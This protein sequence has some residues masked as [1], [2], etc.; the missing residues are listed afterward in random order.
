[1]PKLHKLVPNYVQVKYTGKE[2]SWEKFDET[3][4]QADVLVSFNWYNY[5][6]DYKTVQTL[7]ANYLE[8][9][10]RMDEHKLWAK[11][12]AYGVKNGIGWYARMICMGYPATEA[13]VERVDNAIAFALTNIPAKMPRSS[14]VTTEENAK[15]KAG[16][17]E[18]MRERAD[19]LGGELEYMFDLFMDEGAKSKHKHSPINAL[20][21][22]N[23]L[24]Q[25][26]S[27]L[28]E[29]WEQVRDEFAQAYSGVIK[30]LNESYSDY[31]KIQLRNIVKFTDLVIA[32][33]NSYVTFKKTQRATPKRKV[34]TP[35]QQVQKL[36]HAKECKELNL[37]SVKPEKILGAKEMF[38]YSPKKRKLTYYV[39]DESAGNALMVKNN[40]IVGFDSD[41]TVMKTIRTPKTQIK[42]L[43]KASRPLTRK[44]FKGIRTVEA[45]VS[46]RFADD[47]VILKVF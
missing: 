1:M 9:N 4:R 41:L 11:V 18:L 30:D 27:S 45:K 42:E 10:E 31:T 22:A 24:P 47:L 2:P 21:V 19:L 44:M 29:H 17:Q 15:K 16:I 14:E 33:L 38:V 25:H 28:I 36:K 13:E 39:A 26:T 3:R 5:H 34:K 12:P 46:G 37:K 23:I 8:I 6:F 32:D 43:M 35:Q 7:I 40:T 20:K